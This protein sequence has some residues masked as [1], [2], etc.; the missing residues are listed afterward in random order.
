MSVFL[1]IIMAILIAFNTFGLNQ[2]MLMY[3]D[4]KY[5]KSYIKDKKEK[6]KEGEDNNKEK[7]KEVS[8]SSKSVSSE[9]DD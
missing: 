5:I 2:M 3:Q 8:D 6:P 7:S 1:I 4:V 9:S